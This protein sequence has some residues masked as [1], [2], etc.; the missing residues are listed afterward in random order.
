MMIGSLDRYIYIQLQRNPYFPNQ[1]ESDV[2]EGREVSIYCRLINF[3]VYGCKSNKGRKGDRRKIVS[4]QPIDRQC[5][6]PALHRI[7]HKQVISFCLKYLLFSS[8]ISTR[9]R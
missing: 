3:Q 9:L 2:M 5:T 8:S 7:T 6:C 1:E 4:M